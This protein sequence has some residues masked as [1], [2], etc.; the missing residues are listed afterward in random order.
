M[1]WFYSVACEE[2]SL[3]TSLRQLRSAKRSMD[4]ADGESNP[5]RNVGNFQ[6]AHCRVFHVTLKSFNSFVIT[7]FAKQNTFS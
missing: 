1:R 2:I 5:I 6:P 7:S 3:S 4:L